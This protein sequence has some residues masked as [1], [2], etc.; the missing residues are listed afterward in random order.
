M[1][2]NKLLETINEVL[3]AKDLQLWIL[4]EEIKRLKKELAELRGKAN[5]Q[6]N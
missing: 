2:I 5:E 6:S 4:E 1:K 3:E